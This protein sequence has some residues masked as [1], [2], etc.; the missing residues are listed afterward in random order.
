MKLK[1]TCLDLIFF[2]VLVLPL[3]FFSAKAVAEIS[4]KEVYSFSYGSIDQSHLPVKKTKRGNIRFEPNSFLTTN[5]NT[6][7]IYDWESGKTIEIETISFTAK[8]IDTTVLTKNDRITSSL[9]ADSEE[10]SIYF[11]SGDGSKV[12][13]VNTATGSRNVV[14]PKEAGELLAQGSHR[15]RVH[16][17]L[18]VAGTVVSNLK[19]KP[20][21]PDEKK[22]AIEKKKKLKINF[23]STKSDS[24]IR[25]VLDFG[26]GRKCDLKSLT[27][28]RYSEE[29]DMMFAEKAGVAFQRLIDSKKFFSKDRESQRTFAFIDAKKC[30]MEIFE[31]DPWDPKLPSPRFA[32]SSDGRLFQLV[33]GQDKA[34]LLEWK[35]K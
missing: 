8:T 24:A 27:N 9:L 35:R 19:G 23:I 6:L 20:V 14:R 30:E 3:F 1:K 12:E 16:K 2:G 25:P 15:W 26:D 32:L 4:R 17:G 22:W 10:P 5:Q 31:A 7:L 28:K 33:Y 11:V 13:V 21:T 34:T 18:F 29:G